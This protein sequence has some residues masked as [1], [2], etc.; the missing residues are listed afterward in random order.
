MLLLLLDDQPENL[1]RNYLSLALHELCK[2]K[3]RKAHE[4][5]PNGHRELIQM[6]I[7]S[8]STM[9]LKKV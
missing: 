1:K 9:L 8:E 5:I 7:T 3:Y 2:C 4:T 6:V